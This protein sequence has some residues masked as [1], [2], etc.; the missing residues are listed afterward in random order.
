MKALTLALALLVAGCVH[1]DAAEYAVL[2]G[3]GA[4]RV[5]VEA[6][7]CQEHLDAARALRE[8]PDTAVVFPLLGR[9]P[10]L[11]DVADEHEIAAAVCRV[12][13]ARDMDAELQ[14]RLLAAWR[15]L[16]AQGLAEVK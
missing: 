16:W 12:A 10:R 2:A 14:G 7:T 11:E 6:A 15:R 9:A 4:S 13:D 1:Y 5:E 3:Q 8:G